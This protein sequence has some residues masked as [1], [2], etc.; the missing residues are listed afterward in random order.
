MTDKVEMELFLRE[1][2]MQIENEQSQV[3]KKL[4]EYHIAEESLNREK[5]LIEEKLKDNISFFDDIRT[6]KFSFDKNG[7]L[8]K[9]ED[10]DSDEEGKARYIL[11]YMKESNSRPEEII[12][13][14]NGHNDRYVSSTGCH[15][16]CLNAMGTNHNDKNIWHNYINNSENL[17][18]ILPLIQK[19]EN[20]KK[21]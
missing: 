4:E 13:V 21:L 20:S 16:I 15:T 5:E 17:E 14:G 9:I 2:L 7:Y 11:N 12:F 1:M 10:T 8:V 19:L 6:N 18:D 3:I